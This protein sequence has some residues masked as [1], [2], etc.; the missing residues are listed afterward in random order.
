LFHNVIMP[1]MARA[2]AWSSSLSRDA[3]AHSATIKISDSRPV[4][5]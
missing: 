4:L 2:A 3:Q 5:F 1:D